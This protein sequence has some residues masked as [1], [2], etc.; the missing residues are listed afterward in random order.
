[1]K[2]GD[3]HNRQPKDDSVAGMIEY[4]M[5]TTVLMILLVI[6]LLLV[7]AN[8]MEGPL[9]S[10]T[11]SEF[12]DIGNGV[13]TRIVDLY[14]IAPTDPSAGNISSKYDIP[15]DIVGRG[16]Y[17]EIGNNN[18]DIASSQNVTISRGTIVTR[19]ALAGIGS[20]RRAGGNTTGAG[21]NIISYDSKGF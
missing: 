6:M 5:I 3:R 13:S 20:T 2:P 8:F 9:D 1:M 7:N 11:Y 18:G 10:L 16:Y 12:T 21:I 15:D 4:L 19:V 17:V 14:S